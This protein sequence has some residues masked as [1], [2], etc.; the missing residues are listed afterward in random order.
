MKAKYLTANTQ[1]AVEELALA[2]FSCTKGE[3]V[4][5][6]LKGDKEGD[7]EWQILA[8]KGTE[9]EAKNM[10]ASYTVYY[11]EDGVYLE[12]YPERGEGDR[13][14]SSS[15]SHHLSRKKIIEPGISAVQ[16]LIA[17][18]GGRGK[19]AMS[20]QEHIYGEEMTVV[21]TGD[22]LEASA[23]LLPPEPSG[24]AM[25][26]DAAKAILS[27]AGVTHGIDEEAL[28]AFLSAKDYGEPRVVARATPPIDGDDGKLIF[29]FST[30]ERTG[31]PREIGGGRVDYRSLDL[32]VPVTEGQ[33][34]VTKTEATEGEPGTSVRGNAKAQK[35]GK[36]VSLPRGKNVEVNDERTEMKASTSGMVDFI[37]NTINVSN[38]YKVN[39]DVDMSVGTIDFEGSVQISGS[40]RSGHT[41]KATDGITVGGSVE[42][43]KLIA[44]GSVEV[45]GGM[46]GSGK[47]SI[48]AGGSVTIMYIE[49]GMIDAEGPVK[50]DV[51]IHSKIETG[52]SMH[53][54]GKRGA[55][56]G[57]QVAAAGDIITNFI[58]AVSNTKTEV[59]VGVTPRKRARIQALEKDMERLEADKIKL[60]Q[61]D[62]YLAKTKGSMDNETWTKLQLS[63]VENRRIN[64]ED[65]ALAEEE[66][67]AL[68]DEIEH[69]TDSKVHVFETAFSGSRVIIGSSVYKVTNEIN[70]A[71]FKYDNGEVVYGICE[72]SKGDVK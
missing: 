61:L 45:K 29:H 27:E 57:G 37:N 14:D 39:G 67:A 24:P 52:S 40:V 8:I 6:I 18:G 69:A 44:G 16:S 47:G 31:S 48:V 33:L 59:E 72:K 56:I 21:V 65:T 17:K 25:G 42:A 49:Q 11:E 30:D 63:G 1:E 36:E 34:L 9:A 32:Y 35:P 15:L 68:K 20:Q 64:N 46:Q 66:I 71:T 10:N 41:V 60:N 2:H 62:A 53:A 54:L 5:D 13:L 22:E 23:R 4:I 7:E 55:I 3:L 26:L 19:I 70:Y 50:V 28:T 12:I 38:V 43:A 58:G 51:S